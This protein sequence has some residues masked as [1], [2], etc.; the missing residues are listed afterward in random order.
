M[1]ASVGMGLKFGRY[2]VLDGHLVDFYFNFMQVYWTCQS[3]L[4][5]RLIDYRIQ[6][7]MKIV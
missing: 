4:L 7:S 2:S 6:K 1:C 3:D 5:Y